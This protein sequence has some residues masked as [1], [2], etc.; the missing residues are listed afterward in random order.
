MNIAIIG[1]GISAVS[2]AKTF[3]EAN[4]NVHMFDSNNYKE[5]NRPEKKLKFF[6]KINS[7]PKYND[8]II[9]KAIN[10]F[11]D[12]YKIKTKNFFLTSSLISGGLSNFWGGGIEI[13]NENYLKK[14][15]DGKSILNERYAIDKSIG[16][17]NENCFK[18][19][20]Y[21][22]KQKSIT[23]MLNNKKDDIYFD[24]LAMATSQNKESLIYNSK[25]EINKLL[26]NRYFKYFSDSFVTNVIKNNE[27]YNIE[28]NNEKKNFP[29]LFDKIIISAGTVGSTIIISR[30]LK[31]QNTFRLFHTPIFKLAYFSPFLPFKIKNEKKLE[32]PL[33]QLIIKNKD[34]IFKG[35]F[36]HA[37]NLSN[38]FFG[39]KKENFLFQIIKKFMFIGNI[40][41]HANFSKSFI[42]TKENSVEIYS[43]NNHNIKSEIQ[44]LKKKINSFLKNFTLYEIPFQNLKELENGSDAHYTGTLYDFKLNG[45]KILNNNCEVENFKNLHVLDGS[46]IACGLTYPT[47]FLML[48]TRFIARRIISNDKKNQNKH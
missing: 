41:L 8:Q 14:Y 18:Y 10:D 9:I 32:L 19:Y 3:I 22:Y 21:F 11:K 44:D 12:K 30:V 28:I 7:S 24:K 34:N 39:V 2:A 36:I 15:I 45:K 27:K 13:P 23:N 6:P 4:Y 35:S 48:Y 43:E 29:T 20:N 42:K 25:N 5:D 33:L 17:D 46:S 16:I 40:F 1:S 31:I 47:Y 26:K 37:D 38:Y